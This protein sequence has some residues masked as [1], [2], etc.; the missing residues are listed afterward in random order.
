MP[1]PEHQPDHHADRRRHAVRAVLDQRDHARPT[2]RST[3]SASPRPTGPSCRSP[4]SIR[5]PSRSMASRSRPPPSSATPTQ[6]DWLNGIQ[7][8][9]ITIIAAVRAQPGNG[10]ADDHDQRQDPGQSPPAQ[11]DLDRL[12]LGDRHRLELRRQLLEPGRR[13]RGR[14]RARDHLQFAVRGQ[15]VR[16]D[17]LDSSPPTTTPRSRS[18]SP[19]SSICRPP[20]ST[21]GSTPTTMTGSTSRTT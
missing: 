19:C 16:P 3:S 10:R 21:S 9:I 17:H 13:G 15:S 1:I 12:G 14:P 8:A 6:A 11:R 20:A 4:T 7:D 5:R 2:C 18:L